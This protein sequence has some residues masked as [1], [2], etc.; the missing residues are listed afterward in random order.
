M[1]KRNELPSALWISTFGLLSTFGFRHST[2]GMLIVLL[3][4]A[5]GKGQPAAS[6]VA[7]RVNGRPIF[8][9]DVERLVRESVKERELA[10]EARA[11]L[12]KEALE[13][14]ISR[15][16]ILERLNRSGAGATDEEV[17][18]AVKSLESRAAQDKLTFDEWLKQ[19]SF[20]RDTLRD[21]VAWRIAWRRYLA[22]HVTE[23]TLEQHFERRRRHFDGSH[24]RIAHILWKLDAAHGVAAEKAALE[25]ARQ[26]REQIEV[27]RLSFE[28]AA[29]KYSAAESRGAGGDIGF[30]PRQGVMGEAFS[31]AAFDLEPGKISQPVVTPFGVHLIRALEVRP[32]DKTARDCADALR[33]ALS[34]E[35][36]AGLAAEERRGANV[37]YE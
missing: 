24:M 35:L 12:A 26:V 28:Q 14:L 5:P 37:E 30:L 17:E 6:D 9:L 3:V 18:R 1:T 32:G 34:E 8:A 33:L 13:R 4:A 16:L 27:G 29:Q 15:K 20:T 21:E 7:A 31:R 19:N 22:E 11:A 23:Q 36:F 25:Q 10:P 2:F